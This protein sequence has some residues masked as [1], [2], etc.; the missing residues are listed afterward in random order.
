MWFYKSV[1][2]QDDLQNGFE[3]W[4]EDARFPEGGMPRPLRLLGMNCADPEYF[5][6][7]ELRPRI[8]LYDS[9]LQSKM[10]NCAKLMVT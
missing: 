8:Q 4:L 10:D 3:P 6:D 1:F 2:F 5:H 9:P 7:R